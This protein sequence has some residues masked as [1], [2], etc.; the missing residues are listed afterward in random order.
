MIFAVFDPSLLTLWMNCSFHVFLFDI[1]LPISVLFI[2]RP[3][4]LI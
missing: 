4:W 2:L 3:T 1:L